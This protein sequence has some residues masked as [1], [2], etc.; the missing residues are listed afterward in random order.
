V[1]L[2]LVVLPVLRLLP[3]AYQMG[4]RLRIYRCYRPL[5][6]I[7]R[8][9]FGKLTAERLQEL[10][11]RLDE[12]EQ[13]VNQLKVPASFADQFYELRVHISFVRQRLETAGKNVAG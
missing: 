1:P 9:L 12:V 2:A 3:I 10:H 6:R 4:V 8:D 11:Q 5:L 13:L 7:E